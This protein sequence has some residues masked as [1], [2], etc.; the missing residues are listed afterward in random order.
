MCGST[1]GR[2]L[3]DNEGVWT[4]LD[5]AFG[6]DLIDKIKNARPVRGV[7]KELVER[8]DRSE[9]EQQGTSRP[10]GQRT[11]WWALTRLRL[12]ERLGAE[13][14]DVE[15]LSVF[16]L[17]KRQLRPLEPDDDAVYGVAHGALKLY[18]NRLIGKEFLVRLVEAGDVFGRIS[19][20]SD[21]FVI[22]AISATRVLRIPRASFVGLLQRRP[23]LALEVVQ[24]V[25]E[26][27]RHLVRRLE[28]LAFKDVHTRVAETLLELA[29]EHGQVCGHG[30]AVDIR[31]NQQDLADLVGASRQM[32]NR[33][34]GD[35]SRRLLIQK[36][37]RVICILHL[38]RL[39]RYAEEGE[40]G[41]G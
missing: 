30:F 35:L 19:A 38:E 26:Q 21:E 34:L 7:A 9:Q 33:V 5:R 28:A 6:M 16:T 37:G 20:T 11:H 3:W 31:L 41:D 1:L 10:R 27:N 25:E 24:L 36:M 29:A 32:V 22:Q 18:R 14:L 4:P 23:E 13:P 40:G 2:G 17:D 12:F 15:G 39:R 8:F